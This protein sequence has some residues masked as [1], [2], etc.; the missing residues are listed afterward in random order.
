MTTIASSVSPSIA[1]R[2]LYL[3]LMKKCLTHS[4]WYDQEDDYEPKLHGVAKLAFN[5][6]V[7]PRLKKKRK[8]SVEE[9][10]EGQIWPKFAH[11]MIGFPRLDNI[12]FC[13]QS[14][15]DDNIRGDLIETGVWRGGACIFM[16]AI[17]KA[18]DITDR[19]VW[20]AD[21]FQGL[22]PPDPSKAPADAGA[23]WHT[24][25]ELAVSVEQVMQH[26][27]VY[28]LLD[29]QVKFLKGWF[30]DTLSKAPFKKLAVARLDGDMYES[31]MDSLTNL[32]PKLSPGGYLIVDDFHPVPACKQAVEDYRKEHRISDPIK[33]IDKSGVFWRK[34]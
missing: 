18:N 28:G 32:Y 21:S 17:L 33:D 24:Y 22:P 29:D 4:L 20:V 31:T 13:V 26:F 10:I 23:K 15:I 11:T 9:K 1:N 8:K 34:S 2:E 25:S 27:R 30:K 6:L 14:V 19:T 12:Q 3:D 7:Q 5:T 16:R